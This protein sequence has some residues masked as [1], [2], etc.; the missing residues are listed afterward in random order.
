MYS[1]PN[2]NMRLQEQRSKLLLTPVTISSL[3]QHPRVTRGEPDGTLGVLGSVLQGGSVPCHSPSSCKLRIWEFVYERDSSLPSLP[4][5][6]RETFAAPH[7]LLPGKRGERPWVPTF[8]NV[9]KCLEE[10]EKRSQLFL[11]GHLGSR[12]H[13]HFEME[14]HS[15][16]INVSR[17]LSLSS[18]SHN[19][20]PW[21]VL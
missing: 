7:I 2:A 20:T 10:K 18:H 16:E 13:P 6:G 19:L 21:L 11:E 17:P 12:L 5:K 1:I 9:N 8:W 15:R 4:E 3:A 14:T